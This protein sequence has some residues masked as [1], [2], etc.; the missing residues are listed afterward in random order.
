MTTHSKIRKARPDRAAGQLAVL[1]CSLVALAGCAESPPPQVVVVNNTPPTDAG[2][3]VLLT[4]MI[5]VAFVAT[6]A[7][8]VFAWIAAQERGRRHAA[9]RAQR[10]AEDDL[11]VV[12]DRARG[13]ARYDL[14]ESDVPSARINETY[15]ATAEDL[16]RPAIERSRS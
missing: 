3:P 10:L 5:G 16:R 7:A 9:E 4:V 15:R 6:V 12:R 2:L 11:L 14:P 13:R 8:G 1:S